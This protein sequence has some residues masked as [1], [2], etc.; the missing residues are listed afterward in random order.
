MIEFIVVDVNNNKWKNTVWTG[1]VVEIEIGYLNVSDRDRIRSILIN[2]K[3]LG[4]IALEKIVL[5]IGC[6]L[7]AN[8]EVCDGRLSVKAIDK[9]D[10]WI[11][12]I[13][14]SKCNSFSDEFLDICCQKNDN[15][16]DSGTARLERI[17]DG[18]SPDSFYEWIIRE[19]LDDRYISKEIIDRYLAFRDLLYTVTKSHE[20]TYGDDE[21]QQYKDYSNEPKEDEIEDSI[22]TCPF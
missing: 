21:I 17:K 18:V 9:P 1:R 10:N 8:I 7:F 20:S 12:N 2:G 6:K 19:G 5:P 4:L 14:D 15:F 11:A 22:H 16:D 13:K 3:T